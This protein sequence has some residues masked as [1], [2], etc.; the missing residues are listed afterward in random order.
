VAQ[1]PWRW[2]VKPTGLAQSKLELRKAK[3]AHEVTHGAVVFPR[4]LRAKFDR[5][6]TDTHAGLQGE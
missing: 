1:M 6:T 4:I 3:P 2:G 5:K